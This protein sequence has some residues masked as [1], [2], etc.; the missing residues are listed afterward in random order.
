[1]NTQAAVT[2]QPRKVRRAHC[3]D[4]GTQEQQKDTEQSASD[5][6]RKNGKRKSPYGAGRKIRR[7]ERRRIKRMS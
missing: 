5:L 4:R 7:G 1:M 2:A 6:M 3:R